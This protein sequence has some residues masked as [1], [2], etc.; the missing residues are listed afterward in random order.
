MARNDIRFGQAQ[1]ADF[2]QANQMF[3]ISQEQLDNA[4]AT[5]KRTLDEINKAVTANNDAKIKQFINS[6]GKGELEANRDTINEFIKDVGLQSGNMYSRNEIEEY[7]DNRMNDLIARDNAQML[8]T[9]KNLQHENTLA[10]H[11]ADN[12]VA[13]ITPFLNDPN[14]TEAQKLQAINDRIAEARQA[15]ISDKTLAYAS[16]G[17]FDGWNKAI[18]GQ[19]SRLSGTNQIA[20][21]YL[22]QIVGMFEPL[23]REV[24]N[25][26]THLDNVVAS[27]D[28]YPN[29][30]AYDQAVA[31]ATQALQTSQANVHGFMNA[32]KSKIPIGMQMGRFNE[33]VANILEQQAKAKQQELDN[34]YKLGEL[35][36]KQQ[37]TANNYEIASYNAKTGRMN[38]ETGQGHLGVSEAELSA[39]VSGLIGGGKGSGS[40]SGSKSEA[41]KSGN[42]IF[43]KNYGKSVMN[44][45]EDGSWYYDLPIMAKRLGARALSRYNDR[46]REDITKQQNYSDYYASVQ[47]Q[48]K[49]SSNAKGDNVITQ[50]WGGKN[51]A[52][53]LDEY[54]QKE[55]SLTD[56]QKIELMKGLINNRWSFNKYYNWGDEDTL[57]TSVT[58]FLK[59]VNRDIEANNK[60]LSDSE[61]RD[62]VLAVAHGMGISPADV[63]RQL[64]PYWTDE[65]KG[66]VPAE[67]QSL[68]P[69]K[70]DNPFYA[71]DSSQTAWRLFTPNYQTK[72]QATTSNTSKGKTPSQVAWDMFKPNRNDYGTGTMLIDPRYR[73]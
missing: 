6:F 32:N 59:E 24:T 4:L 62:E 30:Q 7:H 70:V 56:Q 68:L 39:R 11:D 18:D 54:L 19:L 66:R 23:A 67:W 36:N 61:F 42:E 38:A 33:S 65:V 37:Q 14:K 57:A 12:F 47:D 21:G 46:L 55:T 25:A 10:K 29:A 8:N 15:G 9:E 60:K 28:S 49:A 16:S 17:A 69:Q 58:N 22:N 13:G 1:Q 31:E 52:G 27:R 73:K 44:Q 48:I 51:R 3:R 40:G 34:F 71:S 63:V 26:Q 45:S 2:G 50:I 53:Q 41:P 43:D 35:H 20:D 5:G 64:A 72:P